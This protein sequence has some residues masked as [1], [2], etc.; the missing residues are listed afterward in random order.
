MV[1]VIH[2][3]HR[4]VARRPSRGSPDSIVVSTQDAGDDREQSSQCWR[5]ITVMLLGDQ[6]GVD[7]WLP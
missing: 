6:R 3:N 1:A 7:E 5:A 4:A 2:E